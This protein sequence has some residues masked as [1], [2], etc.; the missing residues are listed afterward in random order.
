MKAFSA[1][2]ARKDPSS[3]NVYI[4]LLDLDNEPLLEC[5]ALHREIM[6]RRKEGARNCLFIDEVR[7]LR[8]FREGDQQHPCT[9][10]M[11]CLPH[12]IERVIACTGVSAPRYDCGEGSSSIVYAEHEV[13]SLQSDQADRAIGTWIDIPL[14]M[15]PLMRANGGYKGMTAQEALGVA[16]GA[17]HRPAPALASG[18]RAGR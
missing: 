9:R 10:R 16:N 18:P 2:V 13:V 7:M 4:D 8:G 1:S 14:H 5:H 6:E 12:G 17:E 3:N 11:G 15:N